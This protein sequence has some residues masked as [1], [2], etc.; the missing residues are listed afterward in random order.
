LTISRGIGAKERKR[1][2]SI[3]RYVILRARQD[4]DEEIRVQKKGCETHP[5]ITSVWRYS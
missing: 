3:V 5:E 2:D 1:R 4:I